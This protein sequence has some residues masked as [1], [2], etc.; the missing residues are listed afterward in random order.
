M[1][2]TVVFLPEERHDARLRCKVDVY[3]SVFYACVCVWEGG[4]E[5]KEDNMSY[6][7][8]DKSR[9]RIHENE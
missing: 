4:R 7:R 2:I 9:T 6:P 1:L 8:T 5:R 3:I